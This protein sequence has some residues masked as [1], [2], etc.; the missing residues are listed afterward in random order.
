VSGNN[1]SE[2]EGYG[3]VVICGFLL[4]LSL[5]L[6]PVRCEVSC[7]QKTNPTPPSIPEAKP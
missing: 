1:G 5:V 7:N 6:S 4:L 2:N 3:C